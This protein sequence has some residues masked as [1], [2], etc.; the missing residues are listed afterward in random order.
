MFLYDL[1]IPYNELPYSSS[2]SSSSV[3]MGVAWF[4]HAQSAC[5][6]SSETSV[7]STNSSVITN[8]VD[9]N[10]RQPTNLKLQVNFYQTFFLFLAIWTK[11]WIENFSLPSA[12]FVQPKHSLLLLR[13]KV[14]FLPRRSESSLRYTKLCRCVLIKDMWYYYVVFLSIF[15]S[16]HLDLIIIFLE[17]IIFL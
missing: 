7:N 6:P 14:S 12:S 9:N 15:F 5:Q 10:N 1:S 13:L 2:T 3:N 11:I 8:P 16:L 17:I 4:Y